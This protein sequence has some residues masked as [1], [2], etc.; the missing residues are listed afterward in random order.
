MPERLADLLV[1]RNYITP[2]QLKKASEEQKIK[3]GRLESTL[4]RLGFI[5]EDEL[6]SFLSAQFRVPSVKLS[7]IE[8]NANV[9][10]LIPSSTAKKYFI[11]PVNRV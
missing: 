2:E 6:L 1:K 10:K 11:I 8:I 7:K 9:I 3:G 5:K 4:V